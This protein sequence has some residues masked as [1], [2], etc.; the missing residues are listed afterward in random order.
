MARTKRG[1]ASDDLVKGGVHHDSLQL[2]SVNTKS[3]DQK[4]A[5]I[6]VTFVEPYFDEKQL[7][8]RTTPFE[9]NHN[10]ARFVFETPYTVSGKKQGGVEEQFKRRTILTTSHSFPYVKKRIAVGR[11]QQIDLKPIDVALDEM[12]DR[13]AELQKL[14][15]SNSLDM[16]QLQL[17]LQGCV[18]VQV[19]AGPLAYARAFLDGGKSA[20]LPAKKVKLLKET[21]REFVTACSL[22]LDL[23]ER[24]IKEDQL[25]Y[26]EGLKSNFKDMV[27]ELSEITHEQ[28]SEADGSCHVLLE[29]T[30]HNGFQITRGHFYFKPR[31][32]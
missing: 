3:L 27:K 31:S 14:C 18:S 19:N 16:I 8:E 13:T 15:D 17:K 6:Q 29:W 23:N 1:L 20:K 30:P 25:E 2:G 12:K 7:Q 10:V 22:A 24:L 4:F 21:F 9:R 32:F 11:E 28:V 26:H 5:Y